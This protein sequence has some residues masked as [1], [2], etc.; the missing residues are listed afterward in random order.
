M[1][2][3]MIYW[4]RFWFLFVLS[5]SSSSSVQSCICAGDIK[6]P[7][8]MLMK[9]PTTVEGNPSWNLVSDSRLLGFFPERIL[10]LPPVEVFW[11]WPPGFS[12]KFTVTPW[13]FPFFYIDP[14][15]F[16]CNSWNSNDFY[17]TPLFPGIFY[18]YPQQGGYIFFLEK[19]I[20]LQ[21]ELKQ[22]GGD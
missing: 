13:I 4:W 9:P 11:S 10:Y 12:V 1:M 22:Q 7:G 20:F 3:M 18:W 6:T 21:C 15:K 2:T 5:Y 14:L 17:S 8:I 19:P 16:W